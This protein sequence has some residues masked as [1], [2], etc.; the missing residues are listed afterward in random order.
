MRKRRVSLFGVAFAVLIVLVIA[1][2]LRLTMHRPPAVVLPAAGDTQSGGD[3]VQE[4]SGN[5]IRRV[6]VTPQT[7]QRVIERLARPENYSRT[8]TLERFWT[9][10]SGR[11]SAAVSVMDG[12]T[13]V[14]LAENDGE[15]RHVITGGGK[16]WIWYGADE[17]VFTGAAA[18]S[19]DEE[20]GIPTYED[21]LRLN[22]AFIAAADY[23]VMSG[24][25]CIYVETVPLAS[26]YAE[27]WWVSVDSG[28]LIAAERYEGE[29]LVYRMTALEADI[30]GVDEQS[31]RLPDGTLPFPT[32]SEPDAEQGG[33]EQT[34]SEG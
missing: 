30:G 25:N 33:A 7:V 31:F 10:G 2:L 27:H 18:I 20:Q 14:D 21:V 1:F 28:L 4:A 8:V 23:R 11:T 3:V 29:T 15:A 13:R 16:S 32:A 22:T 24:V 5:A 12:W 34:Q 6:E 19:A 17:R 9:G 26:P